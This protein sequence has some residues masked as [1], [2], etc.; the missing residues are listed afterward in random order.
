MARLRDHRQ[1]EGQGC[2][3]HREAAF[4]AAGVHAY[5]RRLCLWIASLR[6]Q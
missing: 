1:S 3:R 4:A 2:N 6:S 5:G